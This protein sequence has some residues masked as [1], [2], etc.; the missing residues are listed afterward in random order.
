MRGEA[1]A[2]VALEVDGDEAEAG[3]QVDIK[4]PANGK[5]EEQN[6]ILENLV[7]QGYDAIAV[8]V[9]APR[10]QLSTLNG[11]AQKTRLVTFDSD[12]SESKRLLYVGTIN[13]EVTTGIRSDSLRATRTVLDG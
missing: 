8:S 2:P 7:S 13:Y 9:I 5:T 1:A 12:A 6:Q 11:A 4:M 3:V 10:D